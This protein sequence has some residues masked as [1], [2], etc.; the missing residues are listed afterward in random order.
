MT[1]HWIPEEG[2]K[3]SRVPVLVCRISI[4]HDYDKHQINWIVAVFHYLWNVLSHKFTFLSPAIAV[5][6]CKE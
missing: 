3:N 6:I 4:Q 2:A 1:L 5:G